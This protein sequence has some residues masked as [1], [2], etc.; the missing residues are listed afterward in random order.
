MIALGYNLQRQIDW[1]ML[2]HF[3]VW[4]VIHDFYFE[5]IGVFQAIMRCEYCSME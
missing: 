2:L 1:R 4:C 5:E 3:T